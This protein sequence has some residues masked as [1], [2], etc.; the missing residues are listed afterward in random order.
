[1][2]ERGWDE[3]KGEKSRELKDKHEGEEMFGEERRRGEM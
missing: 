2:R 3:G 1:L